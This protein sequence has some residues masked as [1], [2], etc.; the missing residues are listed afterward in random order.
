M[1]EVSTGLGGELT[2]ADLRRMRRL[3][4]PALPARDSLRLLDEAL[5]AGA[6]VVVP[7]KLD[8]AALRART[9]ELPALLHGFARVAPRRAAEPESGPDLGERLAGLTGPERDRLLLDLVRGQ[10]AAV[11]GHGGPQDIDPLRGFLEMG[12]NSLTAVE[13]RNQLV[14]ATG[15]SL[16]ATLVFDRPT[17]SAIAAYLGGRFTTSV[18]VSLDE[19]IDKLE[20]ALSAAAGDERARAA[21]RLRALAS[22]WGGDDLADATAQD[23]FDILDEELGTSN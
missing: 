3:G 22:Q 10:A 13:L 21:A 17:P 14:G 23:L 16:P 11:L 4:L 7:V 9:D 1:W 15:L 2:D 19:E 12:F 5:D 20:S 6:A 8:Q 18:S